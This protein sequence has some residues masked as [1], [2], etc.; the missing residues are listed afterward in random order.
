MFDKLKGKLS[1]LVTPIKH[2]YDL[3]ENS[4]AERKI[5]FPM[6]IIEHVPEQL[7]TAELCLEAVN[8][9]KLKHLPKSFETSERCL[10]ELKIKP[11]ELLSDVESV[12]NL[13]SPLKL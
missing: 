11:V 7:T 8:L 5:P 10:D 9:T 6:I 2:R 1:E 12:E 3:I 4:L 13:P